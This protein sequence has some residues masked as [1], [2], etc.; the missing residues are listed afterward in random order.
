VGTEADDD[1]ARKRTEATQ[2]IV[3]S[4]AAKK[5]IVAGPGT[6]KTFTF[7][8]TLEACGERGLALTFIR[9]LVADLRLAL[10]DIA[11]VFTFH[12]FCKYQLHRHPTDLLDE[13]WHYYP[14]LLELIAHDLFLIGQ[15]WTTVDIE[16]ALH[17]LDDSDRT[18]T[19]TL[20]L[21][22]YYNAVSHT[23]VVCSFVGFCC[24]LMS[25]KMRF[26]PI[27]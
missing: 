25:T 24:I 18:I 11:D 19:E 13:G 5:L 2:A 26:R 9:N 21:G 27:R 22:S 20:R 8:Q 17:T 6:G 10:E 23:D 16:H 4:G 15:S 3:G 12:G 7:R 1:L 14:P